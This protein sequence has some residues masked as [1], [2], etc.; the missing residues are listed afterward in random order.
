MKWPRQ[1]APSQNPV[2]FSSCEFPETWENQGL[3]HILSYRLTNAMIP[4]TA[5]DIVVFA[6]ARRADPELPPPPL[7]QSDTLPQHR[8]SSWVTGWGFLMENSC[9]VM[10]CFMES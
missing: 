6:L 9:F 3:P 1:G 10:F 2:I 7:H 4:S 5:E 8:G